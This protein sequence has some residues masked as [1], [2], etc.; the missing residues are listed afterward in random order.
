[1]RFNWIERHWP[2]LGG[3]PHALYMLSVGM[4]FALFIVHY[5]WV[6]YVFRRGLFSFWFWGSW[7]PFFFDSPDGWVWGCNSAPE[8][9]VFEEGNNRRPG[10]TAVGITTELWHRVP[11]SSQSLTL[12]TRS[13]STK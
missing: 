13:I 10:W 9:A 3:Q 2:H 12:R 6:C 1:L 8:Q 7:L 4:A 11:Q 5:G